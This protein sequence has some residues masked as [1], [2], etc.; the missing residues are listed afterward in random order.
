MLGMMT[1][2]GGDD[3]EEGPNNCQELGD[4]D[5]LLRFFRLVIENRDACIST[6]E[7]RYRKSARG[8]SG[9]FS[10]ATGLVLS[11]VGRVWSYLLY[12][13][14]MDNSERGGSLSNIHAHYNLSNDLFDV[15]LDSET[16]MYSS[17]IYEGG[18]VLG[19]FGGTLE[20]AQVRKLDTLCSKLGL[21][22]AGPRLKLLDIGFGWGGLSIHA[23]KYYNCDVVGITLSVEQ[24]E[25]AMKRVKKEG[26]ERRIEFLVIDYRAFAREGRNHMAFDRVVSCEMIEA[27]GHNHL[28]EFFAAAEAVL[29]PGGVLVMEAI[30]TPEMRYETYRRSADFINTIVF[31]GSCCP[32]LHALV[33]AAQKES[34]LSL[35]VSN[36]ASH[37]VRRQQSMKLTRSIF[38]LRLI[39]TFFIHFACRN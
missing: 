26:L 18:G 9:A 16:R 3:E 37:V 14:F 13:F 25:G 7:P 38:L 15:F 36:R 12:F 1:F 30:T 27:V 20:E 21:C 31:P 17:A 11:Q 39:G 2:V 24:W 8:F 33:D 32:S 23:A 5:G 28:G 34:V 35:E 4:T 10:T 22:K 19:Q 6:T 29:A